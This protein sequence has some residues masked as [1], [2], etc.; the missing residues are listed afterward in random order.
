M[1]DPTEN[2]GYN[3]DYEKFISY[4]RSSNIPPPEK[5]EQSSPIY[6][7][8][9][10]RAPYIE[11]EVGK[12]SIEIAK[13]EDSDSEECQELATEKE[14]MNVDDSLEDPIQEPSKERHPSPLPLNGESIPFEGPYFKGIISSRV[15]DMDDLHD[16]SED[17]AE[18]GKISN[19]TYFKNRSRQFQWTVQGQFKNRT[20][21][22]HVMTGQEFER[23]FR[24]APAV[25]LVKRG[26]NLLKS[27]LPDSFVC[28]LFSETPRFEHP[29]VTGCQFFRVDRVEDIDSEY[30][31]NH[32]HCRIWGQSET[33]EIIEDLSLLNDPAIPKNAEKR[34]KYFNKK[35]N[36]EKFFFEPDLVYSFDFFANFFSPAR[37]CLELTSFFHVDLIPY[38]N[39]Y[40]LFMAMAK[41]KTTGKYLW[42]TEMW[43]KRLLCYNTKPGYVAR[44]L[45]STTF[46][47]K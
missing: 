13:T 26:M 27:R 42:G 32:N 44:L 33:G 15:R 23:P 29:L 6:V 14:D 31:D 35:E 8:G 19:T 39:G 41:D 17:N 4:F 10:A 16:I 37:H 40:P 9:S 12:M 21:F 25:S 5:W 30:F 20:R 22:D 1:P 36:I 7:C 11:Y 34:R 18:T 24:N 45:S 2:S 46:R 38:F 43:H 47:K 3:E 28:D